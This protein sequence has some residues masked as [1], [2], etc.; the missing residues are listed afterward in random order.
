[1]NFYNKLKAV[2]KGVCV[3]ERFLCL[4]GASLFISVQVAG[5]EVSHLITGTL[6]SEDHKAPLEYVEVIASPVSD[7]SIVSVLTDEE[8]GFSMN[9]KE[10]VYILMYRELGETLKQ[11]TINIDSDKF[12]GIITVSAVSKQLQEVTVVGMKKF[13]S[14]DK[15]KLIYNVKNSP[16]AN[17]FNAKDVL[18]SVPG[19]NP[20]NPEE[21]TLI[22]KDGVI[23]QVNGHKSNLKGKDLTN[24]LNNIPSE[25]IDKIEI[26]TNPSSEFSASGNTGILNI[27]LK[28]RKNLGF[29]GSLYTGY[30]QRHTISLENGSNLSFSN[31]WLMMEYNIGYWKEKRMHDVRN[32]FEYTDYC[33]LVNNESYRKSDYISQNL[34]TNI[35]MNDKM[36]LGFFASFNYMDGDVSSD[37]YQKL[38]GSKNLFSSENTLSDTNY[39]G[40]SF[41]PYYEWN[42]DSLGKKLVVNYC[43][44]MTRNNSYSNY[45]SKDYLKVANSLYINRYYVNTCNIDLKLPFSWLNF[46]LGWEY[47]H[48]HADNYAYY[49]IYDAFIYKEAVNSL[50]AGIYKSWKRIYFNVGARYEQTKSYGYPNDETNNFSKSYA[51]FF[52]FVDITY[53]LNDSNVLYIGYNKRINRPDMQQLNPTR[54]YTDAYTYLSGN[55]LLS[56]S[57]MDYIEFRYQ[58]KT[59]NVRVSYIHSSDGIGLLINNKDDS[60]IEQ[61]YSNCISTNSIGGNVSYNYSHNRFSATAQF[62]VN[63]NKSKTTNPS[64][65]RRSLDGFSSFASGNISYMIGGRTLLYTRYLYYFPGQEQY[66]HYR[67]FQNLNLGISWSLIKNKLILN[68]SINDLF[69]TYYNRN[70]VVYEDFVFNNRNNYDNRC[71]NVK[72]T[73][74]FGNNKVKRGDVNIN[75]SNNRIPSAQ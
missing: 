46:E 69:G 70:H 35:F 67:S 20:T 64:L 39:K 51:N 74:K 49:N 58:Y 50:Y 66:L 30:I 53:K 28:N 71:L 63:Y 33:N 16:Y 8:G 52:P 25:N 42:I 47:S 43:Y 62:S 27:V 40:F 29:E 55:S 45:I 72:I 59:L 6:V 7:N 11:D 17:G 19:I 36:N 44:N 10:D 22:G 12:L 32:T 14:F 54:S 61:T 60:Q 5:Q 4:L 13:V 48:Y 2:N 9:L 15:N 38:T 65:N 31:K 68:A 18:L 34:N 75:N 73:Y 21:V 24:Y 3:V 23:V 57:L 41:S 37:V 26:I 56:P 1:M